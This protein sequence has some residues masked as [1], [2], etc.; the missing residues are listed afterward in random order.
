[1]TLGLLCCAVHTVQQIA[2]QLAEADGVKGFNQADGP[3][4]AWQ[5]QEA[6]ADGSI[7]AAAPA[8][9]S[10]YLMFARSLGFAAV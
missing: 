3:K 1:M 8:Q 4:A 5:Q 2:Q 9:V 10:S 6:S 7:P